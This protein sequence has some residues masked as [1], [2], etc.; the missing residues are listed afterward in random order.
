MQFL[1]RLGENQKRIAFT[2]ITRA[3]TTVSIYHA[4]SIPG[5]LE[6]ARAAIE[7]P[8]PKTPLADLFPKHKVKK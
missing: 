3:K 2:A 7:P 1:S 4:G 5:Y 8:K 6:Q